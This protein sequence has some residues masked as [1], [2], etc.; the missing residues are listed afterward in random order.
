MTVEALDTLLTQVRG[1]MPPD[2]CAAITDPKDAAN[3]LFPIERAAVLSAVPKRRAEFAAGRRAARAALIEFGLP[4]LPIPMAEDRAP[5][6][7][8]GMT[9]SISHSEDS[10]IA[11]VAPSATTRAVGVDIEPLEG[12]DATLA[13]EICS[14]QERKVLGG[15][16]A[17]AA[18][19]IFSAKEAAFKAQYPL[20]R[21]LFG[22][23]ALRVVQ[24]LP[25][26][27]MLAFTRPVPPFAPRSLLPVQ[28]WLGDKHILSL[29]TLPRHS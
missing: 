8:R 20:S 12:L 28:Q 7:P 26:A 25:N 9:G 21:T 13:D 10:C 18:R 6:W 11:V 29:A 15:D 2:M 16:P 22:F 27:I 14:D 3:G 4:G 23:D 1:S 5:V 19:R 24:A 17:M